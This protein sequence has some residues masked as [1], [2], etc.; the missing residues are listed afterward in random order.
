[1][2][3]NIVNFKYKRTGTQINSH[4]LYLPMAHIGL[5]LVKAVEMSP[6]KL[7]PFLGRASST[8]SLRHCLPT[9]ELQQTNNYIMHLDLHYVGVTYKY[10]FLVSY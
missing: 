8:E 3:V 10:I 6:V 2:F 1:M 7:S 9:R 4:L 5:G